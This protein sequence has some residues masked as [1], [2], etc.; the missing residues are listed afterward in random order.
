[1]AFDASQCSLASRLIR[2]SRDFGSA[3][4]STVSIVGTVVA[5]LPPN[6]MRVALTASI[7][8]ATAGIV[9]IVSATNIAAGNLGALDQAT[10]NL[11]ATMDSHYS[12]IQGAINVVS[13][14]AG[15]NLSM[16]EVFYIGV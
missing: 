8:N 14:T 2:F 7:T 15:I 10:R 9:Q 13:I 1:M 5:V 3:S 4:K 16:T 11:V 6:P 12:L